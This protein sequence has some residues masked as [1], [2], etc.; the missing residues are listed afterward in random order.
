MLPTSNFLTAVDGNG[1]RVAAACG[2][3]LQR[4][5]SHLVR[6]AEVHSLQC[7]RE[8][9]VGDGWQEVWCEEIVAAHALNEYLL[10]TTT[11]L[12]TKASDTSN[13]FGYTGQADILQRLH[14]LA[15]NNCIHERVYCCQECNQDN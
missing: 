13:M 14:H 2:Q 11:E 3:H 9:V 10:V 5:V 6:V 8:E 12:A 15:V 1:G 4:A 7:V